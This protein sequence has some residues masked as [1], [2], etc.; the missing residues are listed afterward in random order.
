MREIA[1]GL[2]ILKNIFFLNTS[3][4]LTRGLSFISSVIIARYLGVAW[5]GSYAFALYFSGLF[6][7]LTDLGLGYLTVKEV[8]GDISKAG[9]YLGYNITI[10]IFF[11]LIVFILVFFVVTAADYPLIVKTGIYL[12]AIYNI[13]KSLGGI[14]NSIFMA[15]EKM[16]YM[17]FL[18]IFLN[19]SILIGI[20]V[21]T[22]MDLGYISIAYVYL[23]SAG[24]Y[25]LFGLSMV[26]KK[27]VKPIFDFDVS[28]AYGL[29]KKSLPFILATIFLTIF[30][31]ID[32]VMIK[33]IK[34]DL[35]AGY[36]GIS[37]VMI[38]AFVFIPANFIVVM[39]PVFSR[40][41]QNSKGSLMK[42]YEESMRFLMILGIPIGL[43]MAILAGRII[44]LIYGKEYL[45]AAL[46]L[47]I[48]SW[49][50]IIQFMSSVPNILMLAIDR[51]KTVAIVT[52]SGMLLNIGLNY[53][54]ISK[55]SYVGASVATLIT[56]LFLFVVFFNIISKDV[57][58]VGLL[59]IIKKPV[60]TAIFMA[61]LIFLLKDADLFI[62]IAISAFSY[63]FILYL[64]KEVKKSDFD[65]I[66]RFFKGPEI[67]T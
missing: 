50:M 19:S 13:L 7:F 34:S 17:S 3:T 67:L 63:F 21:V 20:F 43:G 61:L 30:N 1:S 60:L 59:K 4:V 25:F 56:Y 55:F 28:F 15:F 47:Q 33:A 51:Q 26:F 36:Y 16:E 65:L 46:S 9:K 35:A 12:I 54:L 29:I 24:I 38:S 62:L 64:V 45:P 49:A 11:S 57:G 14:F 10:R 52:F 27:F 8:S 66:K 42:Y 44:V 53:I 58:R 39:Y 5:F 37:R 48:L 31:S 6:M 2:N 18:T 32:V 23:I 41:Y 40:L 22:K